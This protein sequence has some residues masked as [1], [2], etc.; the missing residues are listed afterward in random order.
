MTADESHNLGNGNIRD[1]T[2]CQ[3]QT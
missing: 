3:G 2:A 1:I